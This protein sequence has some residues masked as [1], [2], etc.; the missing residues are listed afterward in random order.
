[1][2]QDDKTA[3]IILKD[4]SFQ[5]MAAVFEVHNTLGSGF[6]ENVY[7]KSLFKELL[8]RGISAECQKELKV[9]YKGDCVGSYYADVVVN[10]EIILELKTV[11]N[12]NRSHEA[13]LLNYLKA[14]GYKLGLLVNF[15]K[16]KVE[17]KRLVL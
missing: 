5:V 13:Q 6:L 16:E 1:M 2:I 14:T 17:H 3:K 7:E 10:D 15:G 11:E 9:F 12:L 8:L 4:I